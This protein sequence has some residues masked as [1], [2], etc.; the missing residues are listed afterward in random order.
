M[1]NRA[2]TEAEIRSLSA[3]LVGTLRIV[4]EGTTPLRRTP[5]RNMLLEIESVLRKL[6]FLCGQLP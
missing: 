4:S 2:A 6:E 5:F 1:A 3:E